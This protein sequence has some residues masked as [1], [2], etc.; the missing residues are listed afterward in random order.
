M[1]HALYGGRHGRREGEIEELRMTGTL[2]LRGHRRLPE[3]ESE[4]LDEIRKVFEEYRG[5]VV[6]LVVE[7]G[8]P[9]RFEFTPVSPEEMGTSD[10]PYDILRTG[11]IEE[12]PESGLE[13]PLVVVSSLVQGVCL[14]RYTPVCIITRDRSL[15]KWWGL[16]E[17]LVLGYPVYYDDRIP[18]NTILV[19]GAARAELGVG[20]LSYALKYVWNSEEEEEDEDALDM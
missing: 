8:E 5:R 20:G 2:T 12:Y 18:K 17:A 14:L 9:I 11:R 13:S 19:A 4:L 1:L 7:A 16:P 15:W 10:Q 6:K 3:T